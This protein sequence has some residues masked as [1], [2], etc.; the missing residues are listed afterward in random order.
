M[1]GIQVHPHDIVDEG[2]P[3]IKAYIRKLKDIRYVFPEVNTIFE[4]NPNPVGKLPRNP[5]HEVVHGTGTMHA[6]LPP[7]EGSGLDQRREPSVTPDHDPLMMIKDAMQDEEFEVIP[8][9][10]ILN[11][12][13]EGEALE[14]NLVTDV[15]GNFIDHW[16]C[17]N[18]PD[19]IDFWEKT[20]VG[21]Y[22]RYGFTTY[23]IDRIRFPDWG[24]QE[25]NPKGLL[26]CFCPH[27]Q[28]KM[29]K[30]KLD[31]KE[32]RKALETWAAQL[33]DKQ[34]EIAV[35]FAAG[36]EH[37]Q[38]WIK[39]RQRSVTGFVERLIQRVRKVNESF[40]I[41]LDLWPPAYG[42]MLG[43]DYASLTK[44]SPALKHFPYHKLGG[45]AD[46][47]G[48]IHFLAD[49]PE[50]QERAF[51]AF[52]LFFRLPY[53]LTYEAFKSSGFPIQFVA[54]Q[55][56]TVREKSAPGTRI[57]SGIQMWNI[58]PGNLIEAVQAGESSAADD[59]LYYCYGWAGDEL[60]EA[61]QSYREKGTNSSWKE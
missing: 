55:N 10:N 3:Q 22:E 46:V 61:I 45:G 43:Q 25:V 7:Y 18:A 2:M 20:F 34:Y 51:Q 58:S 26:T 27:C 36:N 31:I 60:F 5:V 30:Q 4:R 33:K 23:M 48:L 41:W 59:L 9:L 11:G 44:L 17:P 56:N 50:E 32:V 54:D 15:Y 28:Q 29:A 8:W 14:N 13:F 49:T 52:K 21:L 19:V 16:L 35:A 6:V 37:I 38:A 39:F 40:N 24:G 53:E 12:H 1:T 57:F 42:W 47:Q